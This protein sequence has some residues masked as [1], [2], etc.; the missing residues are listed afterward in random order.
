MMAEAAG[1]DADADSTNEDDALVGEACEG[2][3][4]VGVPFA[5]DAAVLARFDVE[6]GLFGVW[7]LTD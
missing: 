2:F 6:D 1:V 7:L 5:V 3:D 4:V